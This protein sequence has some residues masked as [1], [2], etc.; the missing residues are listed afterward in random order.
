MD[1]PSI[2]E[3]LFGEKYV[4]ESKKGRTLG[5]R[6]QTLQAYIELMNEHNEKL[7]NKRKK[8]KMRRKMRKNKLG[9]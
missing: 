9:M 8:G 3:Y 6:A 4:Y 2:V 7:D 5:M 1:R